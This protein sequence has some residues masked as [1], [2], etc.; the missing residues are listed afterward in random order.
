MLKV[1]IK[2]KIRNLKATNWRKT[3]K[4]K[5]GVCKWQV[6]S[7]CSLDKLKVSM[8]N[9]GFAVTAGPQW[10]LARLNHTFLTGALA[11]P[12]FL[13]LFTLNKWTLCHKPNSQATNAFTLG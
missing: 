1:G 12:F 10:G 11:C 5:V 3:L 8:W 6:D 4:M 13:Q 2:V 7:Q 9:D